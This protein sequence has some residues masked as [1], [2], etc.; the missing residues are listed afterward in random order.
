MMEFT[1]SPILL[2]SLVGIAAYQFWVSIQLA[3]AP[4]YT[5]RQKGLQAVIIWMLPVIGAI[6]VQSM[7]W[8]EGRPPYKPETGYTE[9]GD[10]AS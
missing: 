3:R 1:Q 10:N 6:L 2:V 9:P 4:Q 8:A 7:L 5:G